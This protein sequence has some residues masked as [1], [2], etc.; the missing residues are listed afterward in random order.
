[1]FQR[2]FEPSRCHTARHTRGTFGGKNRI[3]AAQVLPV[4]KILKAG[5][6]EGCDEFRPEML[7]ALN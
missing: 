7:K 5:K 6:A 1:M 3:T 4:V 2:Y